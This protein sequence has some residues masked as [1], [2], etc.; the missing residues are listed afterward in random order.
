[1]KDTQWVRIRYDIFFAYAGT[2]SMHRTISKLRMDST[3]KAKNNVVLRLHMPWRR[4][5]ITLAMFELIYK[6]LQQCFTVQHLY[7][8]ESSD[9]DVVLV[10]LRTRS[11]RLAVLGRDIRESHLFHINTI[12]PRSRVR[13]WASTCAWSYHPASAALA[14]STAIHI[15]CGSWL[16]I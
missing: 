14:P 13:A 3:T 1:M 5:Y 9:F 7:A 11:I 2:Y 10:R 6:W 15:V 16:W 4:N 12:T 8:R